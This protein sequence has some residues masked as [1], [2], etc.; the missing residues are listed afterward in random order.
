MFETRKRNTGFYVLRQGVPEGRFSEGYAGFEQVKP[1]PWRLKVIP[2]VSV[3]GLVANEELCQVA[4]GIIIKNLM[5]K[6]SFIVSE[7]AVV[8]GL[9]F[10][11][12]SVFAL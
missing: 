10:Q 2:G 9:K 5:H 11:V 7:Q 1:W 8:V 12:H 6:Y 4:W 3:V